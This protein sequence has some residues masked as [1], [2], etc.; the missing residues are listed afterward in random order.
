MLVNL[1]PRRLNFARAS[2]LVAILGLVILPWNLYDNAAVIQYFL[3]GLG[4][5]LGPFF[6][7]IAAD[8]WIVRKGRINVPDLYTESPSGTY[9]YSNG[10][11]WKA[12]AAFVPATLAALAVA[13]IPFLQSASAFSWFFGA[14]ISVVL[15][16][17]IETRRGSFE[18]VSGEAIAVE[19]GSP[20][21]VEGFTE[22]PETACST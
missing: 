6:G 11:N 10:I 8:F 17:M 22:I 7:I 13:F 1:F 14:I 3:G 2:I 20:H 16:C 12:M 21:A 15:Y 4:A 19:S 9:F 5:M 18:N